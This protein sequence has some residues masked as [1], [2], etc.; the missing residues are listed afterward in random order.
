MNK[1]M[2]LW[3]V[4]IPVFLFSFVYSFFI[5]SKIAYLPQSEC[6]P[7][8]IFTPQ[9]V[10]YCSEIYPIDLFLISLKTQPLSYLCIISGIYLIGY[11]VYLIYRFIKKRK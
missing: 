5:T 9:D 6:K 3:I 2:I 11:I 10:G 8:F 1:W 7:R 4:S